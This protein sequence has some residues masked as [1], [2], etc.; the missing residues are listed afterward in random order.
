M[1]Y[2]PY[3]LFSSW[4]MFIFFF[5]YFFFIYS[6]FSL[7]FILLMDHVY[8]ISLRYNILYLI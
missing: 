2:S 4:I 8:I 3:G 7:L 5:I 6:S 1:V